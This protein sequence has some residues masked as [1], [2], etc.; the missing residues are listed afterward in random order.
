MGR[1][2]GRDEEWGVTVQSAMFGAAVANARPEDNAHIALIDPESVLHR[3]AD[4]WEDLQLRGGQGRSCSFI[5]FGRGG[6]FTKGYDSDMCIMAQSLAGNC[7][8]PPLLL[9]L[10]RRRPHPLR[11]IG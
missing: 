3:C 6:K 10:I 7:V 1:D 8:G 11:E 4:D 2:L 5:N 9:R